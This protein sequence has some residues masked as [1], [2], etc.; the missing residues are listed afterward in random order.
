MGWRFG[1]RTGS[2]GIANLSAEATSTT[3]MDQ[4][5]DIHRLAEPNR[6]IGQTGVV[7]LGRVGGQTDVSEHPARQPRQQYDERCCWPG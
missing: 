2:P 7:Q 4:Q 5:T 3:I 1:T 6:A